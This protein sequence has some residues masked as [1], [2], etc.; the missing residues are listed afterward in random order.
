MEVNRFTLAD[1]SRG[2]QEKR[3]GTQGKKRSGTKR[4]KMEAA[5]SLPSKG[6]IKEASVELLHSDGD[7]SGLRSNNQCPSPYIDS[8]TTYSDS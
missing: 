2:Q 3:A 5:G 6:L 1:Y 7:Q 8:S 4:Q